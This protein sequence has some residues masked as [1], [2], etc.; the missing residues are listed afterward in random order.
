MVGVNKT[1]ND[2]MLL[3]EAATSLWM[4]PPHLQVAKASK[5]RCLSPNV[6]PSLKKEMCLQDLIS[7]C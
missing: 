2:S 6:D 7:K 1:T 5:V 3:M 4:V